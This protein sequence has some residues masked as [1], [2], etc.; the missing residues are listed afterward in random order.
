M[1]GRDK[2]RSLQSFGDVFEPSEA[3]E[4][5]LGA[6]VRG[7]LTEW[8]SEIWAKDA[9]AEVG[10]QPRRR[11]VFDGAPGVGKTTLAH[12]LAARLGLSMLAVRPDRVISKYVGETSENLGTLFEAAA[13]ADPPL[14]LFLDEFNT[15][16]GHRRAVSQGSDDHHNNMVDTLLQ[17][18]EQ[19]DGLLIA[20]TNFSG[21]IDPAIWRRFDIHITLA[22]PGQGERRHIIAR[23]LQPYGLP[24]AALDELARAL[25]TAS[26]ALIRSLCEGLKRQIVLGPIIGSDMGKGAVIGRILA[27]LHPH[28]DCGKPRLW[29][30]GPKD[31]AIE[32]MPW[33]LPR[34]GAG[35]VPDPVS[36]P[37]SQP[38]GAADDVISLAQRRG[39]K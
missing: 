19:Y 37:V 12:H 8:L 18:L 4:P 23:Y 5:I 13:A 14:L 39:A 25:E 10:L 9:L 7:A 28:E 38:A 15:Y 34:A 21:R 36:D 29:S 6:A 2:P 33:P 30:H 31:R 26:P 24:A 22:M 35:P 3:A 16:S 20:A 17:R 32:L 11:A 27:G 1:F